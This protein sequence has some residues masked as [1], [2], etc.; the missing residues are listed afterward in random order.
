M[1]KSDMYYITSM[2]GSAVLRRRGQI[3]DVLVSLTID[4]SRQ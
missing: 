1:R 2:T 3:N 4:S